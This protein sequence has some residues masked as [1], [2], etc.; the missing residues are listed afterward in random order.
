L[1]EAERRIKVLSKLS[2][3]INFQYNFQK[4]EQLLKD[5]GLMECSNTKVGNNLIRG[6]SGG[7]RK[8]ASI[9][10]ELLTNPSVIFLDEPTTGIFDI[11]F[12][13][14]TFIN[15]FNFLKGLDSATSFH[16]VNIL[17]NLA[18]SGRTV[19]STIHQ[20]SSEIFGT[21][22]KLLLMVQGKIIYQVKTSLFI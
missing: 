16:V 9:G 20:P 10:V 12:R 11:D 5:L 13:K 15:S 3:F 14:N 2:I 1:P 6:I 7:E 18:K 17:K 19:I 22:D 4:V 8:R 21:F